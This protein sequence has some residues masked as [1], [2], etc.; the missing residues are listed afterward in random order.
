M[1]NFL[2]TGCFK[3][4]FSN[5]VEFIVLQ[6]VLY[7]SQFCGTYAYIPTR[8][9]NLNR[10]WHTVKSIVLLPHTNLHISH[11]VHQ[12]EQHV[13]IQL[14]LKRINHWH[15]LCQGTFLI[16][17]E[18][19][20]W[21]IMAPSIQISK[22]SSIVYKYQTKYF[23]Q[24]SPSWQKAPFN[25]R[26]ATCAIIALFSSSSIKLDHLKGEKIDIVVYF[27]ELLHGVSCFPFRYHQ[28]LSPFYWQV[29]QEVQ[30]YTQLDWWSWLFKQA[31]HH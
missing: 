30:K 29:S 5:G 3:I 24:L 16:S 7:S 23:R 17:A 31:S 15:H 19:Q 14:H 20:H 27:S 28:V 18:H 12:T 22:C 4:P 21:S 13:N 10:A 11:A 26:P 25:P 8:H 6:L 1:T 9:Y 2:K